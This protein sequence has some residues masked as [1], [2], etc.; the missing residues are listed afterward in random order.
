M[1]E[2]YVD[3]EGCL[4][5]VRLQENYFIIFPAASE[6]LEIIPTDVPT[7]SHFSSKNV[8]LPWWGRLRRP[9]RAREGL[10]PSRLTPIFGE[11]GGTPRRGDLKE[12]VQRKNVKVFRFPF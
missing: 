12:E 2:N 5:G 3:G 1:G 11:D 9:G 6:Q 4:E 7:S 10:G 8:K